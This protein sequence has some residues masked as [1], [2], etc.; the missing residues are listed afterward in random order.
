MEKKVEITPEQRKQA[1]LK[2]AKVMHQ[3]SLQ[4]IEDE[5]QRINKEESSTKDTTK[6]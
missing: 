2:V 1:I 6:P 3:M 4:Q 5:R